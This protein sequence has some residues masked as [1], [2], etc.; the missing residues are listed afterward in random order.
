MENLLSLKDSVPH[1]PYIAR[2]NADLKLA[3][4]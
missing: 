1:C 2:A 4:Q 3:L